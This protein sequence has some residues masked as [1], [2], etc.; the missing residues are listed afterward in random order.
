LVTH[1]KGFEIVNFALKEIPSHILKMK[2]RAKPMAGLIRT[3]FAEAGVKG[4]KVYFSVS[5]HNVVIRRAVLPK[6][7]HDELVEAARW[8]A[9]EE[10]LFNVDTASLD[11]YIQGESRAEGADFYELLTVVVREDVIPF[12]VDIVQQAGLKPLGVTV[13]PMA[14]WDYDRAIYTPEPGIVSSY[15]DMGSERTRVY[16]VADGQLLFSREI[17]NGGKNITAAIIG[18]YET[19]GHEPVE[20][21]EIR[22]EQIKKSFGLPAEDDSG[23]T[24]EGIPLTL[25]R[26]RA[27]PVVSKQVEEFYRSIEY[28]KN[29]YKRDKVHRLIISGGGVGLKGLYQFMKESLEMEI[30]R[31][32]VLFQASSTAKEISKEDAK[33]IGPSLTAAAGLALG[34]CEKID[35]LPAE[36]KGSLKKTLIRWAPVLLIPVLVGGVVSHSRHMRAQVQD[37]VNKLDEKNVLLS[38]L[39]RKVKE[40]EAPTKELENLV[41]DRNQLKDE[42]KELPGSAAFPL[43]FGEVLDEIAAIVPDN[44]SLS[45]ISYSTGESDDEEVLRNKKNDDEVDDK[46]VTVKGNIFGDPSSIQTTLKYLL[47]DFKN[48]PA[49]KDVKLIKSQPLDPGSYN[50]PGIDFELYVYPT[51][52]GSV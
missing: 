20:V 41:K 48:S 26:E 10:I 47:E 45:E 6:M 5:G 42:K 29:Q 34:R 35:V 8:N 7:P 46:R 14:L 49:V 28:F 44:A 31:C 2:D 22:A 9:K 1:D 38:Q 18:E 3:L 52:R 4:R 23:T 19:E 50:V 36:L 30:E 39:Q 15:I 17:P 25:I 37:K 32:N 11:Y 24:E 13:V 51:L 16:F 21:D 12:M 40:L 43:D 27:F 33:L